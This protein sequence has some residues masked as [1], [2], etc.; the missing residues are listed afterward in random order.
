[1]HASARMQLTR[2]DTKKHVKISL[3]A[4][5][6]TLQLARGHDILELSL[7]ILLLYARV[8][9]ESSQNI[10]GFLFSA[11]FHEPARRFWEEEDAGHEGD[12][13]GDLECDGEA[14]DKG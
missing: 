12:Q 10:V 1:M 2:A 4:K 7:R 8:A 14:P 9:T 6:V 5:V 3:P 13:H 11:H